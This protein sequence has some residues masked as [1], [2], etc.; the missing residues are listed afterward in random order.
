MS[1]VVCGSNIY[2]P[3]G[4]DIFG[5]AEDATLFLLT[6]DEIYRYA[7]SKGREADLSGRMDIFASARPFCTSESL[8]T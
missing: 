2:E 7:L 6:G 8:G 1:F 4:T 5:R 3:V